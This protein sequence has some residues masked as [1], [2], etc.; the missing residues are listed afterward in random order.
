MNIEKRII[1]RKSVLLRERIFVWR[2]EG[3]T[4]RPHHFDR[5]GRFPKCF[6]VL[7]TSQFQKAFA[8]FGLLRRTPLSG[9]LIPIISI[10]KQT[11]RLKRSVYCLAER[12]GFEPPIGFKP[13]HDFQSCA[14][15]QLSHLSIHINLAVP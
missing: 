11:L 12:G 9:V 6:A 3:D 4:L 14:L 13:I 1:E 10:K 7:E 8:H 15:D 5:P 2:R